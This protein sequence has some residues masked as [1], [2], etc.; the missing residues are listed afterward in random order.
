MLFSRAATR[1]RDGR[2]RS[3][4]FIDAKKA[5]L[6]PRC[7]DAVYVELPSEYGVPEGQCA[8]LRVSA[9]N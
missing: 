5:H 3:F 6:N 9:P 1:R 8:K 2:M 4:M 7:E